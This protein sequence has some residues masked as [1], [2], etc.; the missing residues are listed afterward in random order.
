MAYKNQ[1]DLYKFHRP[2]INLRETPYPLKEESKTCLRRLAS[3]RGKQPKLKFPR[4]RCAGVLV[5]LFVGRMG[6]LYVLLSRRSATLRSYAG[7]TS[8]PGGKVEP[9]DRSIEETA[10]RE[11]FEEIGLPI[12]RQKAPLLCILQ[13]FMARDQLIVT[14]VVVLILDND[15]RPILNT[16]EVTSIFSHPLAAFL[17]SE[18]P[19]PTE[20]EA[21]ELPYHSFDDV[22]WKWGKAKE[23]KIRMHRF[24]TGREAG[25]VKP[26]FGL[27]AAILI[28]AATIGYARDPE[29]DLYAD[30]QPTQLERIVSAMK[31]A[32]HFKEA[33]REE[34][35][36]PDNVPD[37][38]KFADYGRR[39]PA[40]RRRARSRL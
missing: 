9:Q 35:L 3:Y 24:L 39:R 22:T 38:S 19:F 37:P 40:G 25:G 29:F 30:N 4:S 14:P 21:I 12:D 11:A 20:P 2:R 10:R 23:Q 27:T 33:M 32:E 18:S 17:S 34:G 1:S 36:D 8:L 15:V 6:D 13:P 5:A 31:F 7:D 16:A 28:E 26:V